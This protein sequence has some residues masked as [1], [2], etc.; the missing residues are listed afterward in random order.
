MKIFKHNLKNTSA[1]EIS[2]QLKNTQRVVYLKKK[3]GEV[4]NTKYYPSFT[5]EWKNTI[6]SYNKNVL[7]NIPVNNLNINKIIQS[8]FNLFFKNYKDIGSKYLSVRK[9]RL[10]FRRIYVSNP[11]I[12]YTNNKAIITLYTMNREKKILTKKY[13]KINETLSKKLIKR[14]FDLYKTYITKIDNILT[15]KYISLFA[16]EIITKKKYIIYKLVYLKK[17]LNL[18]NL[19]SKKIWSIILNKYSIIHLNLLRKSYLMYSLNQSKFNK[20]ILLP[21]LSNILTKITGKKIEYKIINLKS[22]I[23]N[24]DIFTNILALLI[25]KNKRSTLKKIYSILSRAELPKVNTIIE[26]TRI[27]A[28][29]YFFNNYRDLKIISLLSQGGL[30]NESSKNL[31]ELIDNF[32]KDKDIHSI[33]YNTIRYKNLGGIRLEVKGRLT[34]RY[35][36]DRSLYFMKWKGGL[37]NIDSSYQGLSSVLFKGNTNSNVSYSLSTTK[38]RIGAFAV[39][40][41]IGAK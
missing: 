17:F 31:V 35:R 7:K 25:K 36:S 26:R 41:W 18:K 19:Y 40:G 6:Y 2:Q 39:K 3:Y 15:T 30:R 9:R 32:Y 4:G 21:R 5:K 37:K 34:T 27:I 33:I 23:Y 8:Y 20:L 38:R 28:K 13:L 16:K 12:Q 22:I 24:T 1:G 14:Y 10:F 11:E 29:N